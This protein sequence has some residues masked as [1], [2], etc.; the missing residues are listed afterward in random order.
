MTVRL[1]RFEDADALATGVATRLLNALI[2][3]QEADRVAQLC[4]TGGRIANSM[5]RRFAEQARDSQLA[6]ARLELWWGDERFLPSGHAD[7]NT[8]PTLEILGTL[9]LSPALTHSM[10]G[11]DGVPDGASAAQ[12]YAEELGDT[13][14]D[15]CLLGMGPD[16][17]VA[18]IFPAHPSSEPTSLKVIDVTDA[19]KPP[20]ERIS[21]TLPTLNKST[22]IWFLVSG[23]DK[24]DA[25]AKAF[26]GDESVPGGR[27]RG[28]GFTRFFVDTAAASQIGTYDCAF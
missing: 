14:F 10:S 28:V 15:I 2:L 16:G 11:S 1:H 4:L 13:T 17:H 19:P 3:L 25:V 6:P 9:G 24:A 7:R 20:P 5:Y 23:P 18:S 27:T 21:L 12:L 8:G 22:E 26:A